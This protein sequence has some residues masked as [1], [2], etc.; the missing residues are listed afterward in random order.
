[1][2]A[3]RYSIGLRALLAMGASTLALTTSPALAQVAPETQTQTNPA[4]AEDAAGAAAA[5]TNDP[6]VGNAPDSGQ[7]EEIVVTAQFR[8]QNLQDT[9]IAITAV[10]GAMLEARS[11]TNIAQVANQAPSVTLKPQGAAFGPSMGASIR[12]VGQ[13]DFNP[14]LEPGVG[15]Y[16]DDVYYATLTGALF[17]LL[18]LERVEILRG[19][20]GTLAGKNSIGGA[21]KLYSQRPRGTNSGYVSGTYGSRNRMDL[22]A[23]GD[24]RLTDTVAAR[25]AGVAKKQEGY[26]DRLDFGCVNPPGSAL[27]PSSATQTPIPPA[28]GSRSDCVLAR[29]GE[30]DYIAGRVQLRWQPTETIDVNLVADYTHDDRTTAGGVLLD[31]SVNGVRVS[32]NFNGATLTRGPT[33]APVDI[34]PFT[35]NVPDNP[36]TPFVEVNPNNI[37]L[38]TR[39]LCGP[40]CNYASFTS[41][42][43]A[44]APFGGPF[45]QGNGRTKFNGWGV[46]GQVD[47][48]LGDDLQLV[49]ITAYREYRTLFSNDDDFTPLA[50]SLGFGDLTFWSVSQELRLNGS[51]FDDTLEYTLGGFYMD[52]RSVYAT[53]QHLRYAGLPPFQGDDPVDAGT[54]ALFA[55][56]SWRPIDPLT[57]TGGIRF[58][59]EAKGYTYTRLDLAGTLNPDGTS[60]LP[61]LGPLHGVT[62]VYDGEESERFDYRLNAQYEITPN[63]SVYAQYSTGFKG[64]GINP[65][66]FNAQ[67]VKPFSPETLSA[68]ELGW[69]SDLF[70]RRVRLNI[71]AFVGEYEDIQLGLNNC[72]GVL[73]ITAGV[74][75]ALPFNAGSAEVKGIEV[76]TSIRP[77]EGFLIDGAISYLDF[78]YTELLPN[79]GLALSFVSPNTPEWKWSLG[80]QYEIDLATAGSITPRFDMAY[81]SDI[82]TNAVNRAS[83]LIEAYH[84]ANARLTWQNADEDL[85][86]SAEVTNLFDKYYL[87]TVFDLTTAGAGIATGQPG[88]PREWALS[89]KKKF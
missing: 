18:D 71:A 17:D 22:R 30:V 66:P 16:I 27:N 49:S 26:V 43:D 46:S 85:E 40:Y 31:R 51:L 81:Q 1:M 14:A 23:S 58:T 54:Q 21:I 48:E 42:A 76:E 82:F 62:G 9:P 63:I 34:D 3:S 37:P 12:G 84:L 8:E 7:V 77:A 6:G 44:T 38:D 89:V 47:W 13:F 67:Q 20:Q 87:L 33:P 39:F 15:L 4:P 11:Q 74:P 5:R 61:I 36:A 73:G 68:Y 59:D 32:P 28:L 55:H 78:Q 80:A 2:V 52:Q 79:T 57:L 88:R 70:D 35:P 83:N 60:P 64:G 56:V 29:E 45:A 10:S 69:K 50:H 75:C 19:P 25:V 41:L 72:T 53:T 24:F 86:I 65:R